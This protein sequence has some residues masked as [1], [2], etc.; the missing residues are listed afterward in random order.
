MIGGIFMKD[1]EK[2]ILLERFKKGGYTN[3]LPLCRFVLLEEWKKQET[4]TDKKFRKAVV[5][6]SGEMV[7]LEFE[8]AI[9]Q[10]FE[11]MNAYELY[12]PNMGEYYDPKPFNKE[13]FERW[14]ENLLTK[15]V[16]G[17]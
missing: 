9:S 8:Y 12:Y 5:Q 14:K 16:L 17:C 3:Y 10:C 6:I 7:D 4:L 11:D 15:G 2:K 1:S 13:S